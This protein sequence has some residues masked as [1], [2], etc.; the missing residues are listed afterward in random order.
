MVL[1]NKQKTD[2]FTTDKL[3][4]KSSSVAAYSRGQQLNLQ[5]GTAVHQT[6]YTCTPATAG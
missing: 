2:N 4:G 3:S 5:Q 1:Q 6:R